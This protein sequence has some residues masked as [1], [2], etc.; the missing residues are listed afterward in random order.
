MIF[1]LNS[2]DHRCIVA[3]SIPSKEA[4]A[5]S[6]SVLNTVAL[7]KTNVVTNEVGI[8]LQH[9]FSPPFLF[10]RLSSSSLKES[11]QFEQGKTD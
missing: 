4:T 7:C 3:T 8:S 1:T 5:T 10:C 11:C 9:D 6:V 2:L